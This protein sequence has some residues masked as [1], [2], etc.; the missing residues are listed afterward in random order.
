MKL[1]EIASWRAQKKLYFSSSFMGI[2]PQ[3]LHY[4]ILNVL[5]CLNSRKEQNPFFRLRCSLI[6]YTVSPQTHSAYRIKSRAFAR[7][8]W[9]SVISSKK[10][11]GTCLGFRA[12][13]YTLEK[14]WKQV[15]IAHSVLD[16]LGHTLIRTRVVAV[17]HTHASG[18]PR[19]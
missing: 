8:A 2:C 11:E 5:M 16:R 9:G 14:K 13:N 18:G 12:A 15:R 17:T 3:N 4:I 6:C 7:V 10:R 19:F 1:S